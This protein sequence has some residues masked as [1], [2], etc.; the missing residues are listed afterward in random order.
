MLNIV[1]T[2]KYRQ[3]GRSSELD[4]ARLV[5]DTLFIVPERITCNVDDRTI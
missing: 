2:N 1:E 4:Q 5:T 3:V